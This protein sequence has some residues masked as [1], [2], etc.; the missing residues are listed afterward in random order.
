MKKQSSSLLDKLFI[1]T[2]LVVFGGVILHAPLTVGLQT[3]FPDAALGIKAWKEVVLVIA[4]LLLMVILTVRNKWSILK[5]PIFYVIAVYAVLHLLLIPFFATGTASVVS[6]LMIDL[7]YI[8]FFVLVYAAARMYPQFSKQFIWVGV[9]GALVVMIFAILQLTVLP[10]D[11]LKHIGYGVSTIMPFM[12]VDENMDFIRINSTLRGPNPLGAYAVI[13]LAVAAAFLL[14]SKRALKNRAGVIIAIV[15][16]GGAMALWASYS[17]SALVAGVVALAIIALV[18]VA[19]RLPRWVWITLC[20]VALGLA[21]GLYAARDTHF[22]SHVILHEDPNEGNDTNSNDGHVE[23][24]VDG[25]DRMMSQPIGGGIGSTGSASLLGDNPLIIE[26]QYLYIAHEVGWLGIILFGVLF[27]MLLKGLW[28]KRKNWLALGIF[29]SGIGL[30][31]IGL[32]LPVWA[33]DTVSIVW[34]GLA[35]LALAGSN[36]KQA[37][38]K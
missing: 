21:G 31:L 18:T 5:S 1:G 12:T 33:D 4:S 11:I 9:A 29:A 2:L 10:Y 8:L 16:V 25:T 24:L 15:S 26:N 28:K 27:V 3:L 34:W 32:L 14:T 23:S 20:V 6:G 35:A 13:V 30:A 19:R 38:K 22:I 37:R 36:E 17:R 7:R